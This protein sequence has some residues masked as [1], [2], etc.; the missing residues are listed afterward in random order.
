[1]SLRCSKINLLKINSIA[2]HWYH[3]VVGDKKLKIADTWWQ[4][5]TGSVLIS[6]CPSNADAKY[7]PA[8]PMRP[9]FG[10]VPVLLDEAVS[11]RN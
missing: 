3:E 6:P 1:M 7:H 2:W 9:F 5:E 4:T 8:M 10:V 11:L